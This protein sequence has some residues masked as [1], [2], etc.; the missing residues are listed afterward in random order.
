LERGVWRTGN[1]PASHISL[2]LKIEILFTY[3]IEVCRFAIA[4]VNLSRGHV[5]KKLAAFAE[6][7]A[8]ARTHANLPATAASTLII[9]F[10]DCITPRL[11]IRL[12]L[13]PCWTR[14]F[15][16]SIALD[17]PFAS[18]VGRRRL[19]RRSSSFG[20]LEHTARTR[21]NILKGYRVVATRICNC[22]R[23]NQ[24]PWRCCTY[25]NHAIASTP[26]LL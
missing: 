18:F 4:G 15:A 23:A 21:H 25:P 20:R 9:A 8:A 13:S 17:S 5:T 11:P 14:E 2:E 22:R 16:R 26:C 10:T 19:S 1:S 12:R 24:P 3:H 7:A 6:A